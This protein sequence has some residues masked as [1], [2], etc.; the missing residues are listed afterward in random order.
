MEQKRYAAWAEEML[1]KVRD[2][3]AWVSEKNRDRI[4]YT[5]D[6]KGNLDR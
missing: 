5:T 1:E 3:M 4:P 2:K 6:E